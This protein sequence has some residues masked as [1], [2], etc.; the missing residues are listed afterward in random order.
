MQSRTRVGTCGWQYRHWRGRFYPDGLRP[1]A[2]LSFYVRSF[3]TV[4]V[5]STFYRTP[6]PT[7]VDRW[8]REAPDGFLFTAKLYRLITHERRLRPARGELARAL[9]PLERLG[10]KRGPLLVQ[11]PSAF[12][13]E[14]A[15]VLSFA[16]SIRDFKPAFE[17]RH[18]SWFEDPDLERRINDAGG[19][20]VTVDGPRFRTPVYA[21]GPFVYLRLHG[22][23]RTA[24]PDYTA[25]ELDDVAAGLGRDRGPVLAYF[26]NDLDGHA[27]SNA[28]ALRDR[29]GVL[30]PPPPCDPQPLLPFLD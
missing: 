21:A 3:D 28:R 13:R 25:E 11:L 16:R 9:A 7:A 10:S 27:V 8:V 6:S 1:A 24:P 23:T 14:T 12:R 30:P 29:L 20:L 4:E 18:A 17:F 5:N 19:V 22:R 15:G 2:W 26:N